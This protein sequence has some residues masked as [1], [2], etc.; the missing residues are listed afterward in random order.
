MR[1]RIASHFR[2]D[3]IPLSQ[4]SLPPCGPFI[5]LHASRA[6]QALSFQ[7]LPNSL[8]PFKKSSAVFSSKSKLFSQNTGG[9]G[10]LTPILI[11]QRGPMKPKAVRPIRSAARCEHFTLNGRHVG[12]PFLAVRELELS[13]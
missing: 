8:S 6:S 2:S 10:T 4:R 11:S 1:S 12:Q 5:S 9:G 7:Q 3:A 13:R